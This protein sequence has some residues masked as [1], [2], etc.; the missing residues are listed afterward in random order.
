[1]SALGLSLIAFACIFGTALLSMFVRNA[2]PE[3]HLN[4][5]S[6]D[7][8]RLSM[9]VIGTMS[10]LV[11]GLLIASA[12]S[13]YDAKNG[14]VKQ[15]AANVILL[16]QLLA[17]YGPDAR[18]TRVLLRRSIASMVDKIWSEGD[19]AATAAAYSSSAPRQR[20]S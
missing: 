16:D 9:G 14:Q 4:A 5:D 19:Q 2:L 10:A 18:D 12:K 20:P 3:H 13:S 15:I 17:Q 1:M 8:I 7:A 6:R 11:L